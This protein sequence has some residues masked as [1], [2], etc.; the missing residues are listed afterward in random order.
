MSLFINQITLFTA[1][2][3]LIRTHAQA[4]Q[5]N[6]THQRLWFPDQDED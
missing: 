6:H 3:S 4:M 5:E 1:L 2:N